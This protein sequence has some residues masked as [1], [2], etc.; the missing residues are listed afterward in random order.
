M[1]SLTRPVF[2]C[3]EGI[4]GEYR[5]ASLATEGCG[6][7]SVASMT[8]RNHIYAKWLQCT[9]C[10]QH[11]EHG[12]LVA[13]LM[14]VSKGRNVYR[15][16]GGFVSPPCSQ[17]TLSSVSLL[18]KSILHTALIKRTI[19]R[20]VFCFC[21]CWVRRGWR[22]ERQGCHSVPMG[23]LFAPWHNSSSKY[24]SFGSSFYGSAAL[25]ACH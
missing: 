9:G 24:V 11:P 4:Y 25:P 3:T 10:L 8:V 17:K 14:D 18:L 22:W 19:G 16:W 12:L 21:D 5:V 2:Y 23:K 13:P 15:W 20:A 6:V 1:N 7:Y